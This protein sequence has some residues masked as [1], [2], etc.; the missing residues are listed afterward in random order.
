MGLS[1]FSPLL[2]SLVMAHLPWPCLPNLSTPAPP[3]DSTAA[4][5]RWR[6]AAPTVWSQMGEESLLFEHFFND[7]ERWACADDG[8]PCMHT[9]LE[10]GANDG[11]SM[12]NTLSLHHRFGWRGVLVEAA[13]RYCPDLQHHRCRDVVACGAV[14][15]RSFG[16]RIGIVEN[17]AVSAAVGMG[18]SPLILVLADECA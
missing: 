16:G 1:S 4:H 13:P 2:G 7:S 18:T 17:G 9:Y 5:S 6:S 11:Q 10:L 12:S 14:C 3:A 15:S 8:G